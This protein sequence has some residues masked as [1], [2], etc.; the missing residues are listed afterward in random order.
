MRRVLLG[1]LV[2]AALIVSYAIGGAAA[3]K[4]YQFTGI[5][6]SE[7]QLRTQEV[8]ETSNSV[9]SPTRGATQTAPNPKRNARQSPARTTRTSSGR[10]MIS[11]DLTGPSGM[12]PDATTRCPS[13]TSPERRFIVPMKSA[14]NAVAGRW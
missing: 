6:K 3:A 1:I 7:Q 8:L 4:S 5:V 2:M 12:R 10:N 9:V 13:T 14:T 11:P